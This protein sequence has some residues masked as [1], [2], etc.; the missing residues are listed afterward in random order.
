MTAPKFKFR[1]TLLCLQMIATLLFTSSLC[2]CLNNI[3][4]AAYFLGGRPTVEPEFDKVTHKSMTD[5]DVTVAVICFA[6]DEIRYNFDNIHRD[7]AKYV[8]WRL[9]AKHVKVF[10]PDVVNDWLD[11]HNDWD[12][13]EE[14]GA[15]LD[16][17]YVIQ[18]DMH[19]YT[20]YAENSSNLYQGR[21]ECFVSVVEMAEDGTGEKIF[22]K[23]LVSK[24]PLAVPRP[25]TETEY[26]TFRKE[27]LARL[28]DEIGRL[29]YE[30]ENLEDIGAAT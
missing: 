13:P 17:T 10:N 4:A 7:I 9:H 22:T 29:F 5:K 15:A 8:T 14:I 18:I 27:Y 26:D 6:G 20:L 16:A 21:A 3:I 2:G 11:K 19:S 12:K 25:T 30:Y 28:S 1:C 24:Y 23:E